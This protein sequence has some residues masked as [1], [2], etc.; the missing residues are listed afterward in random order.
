MNENGFDL[1]VGGH[2]VILIL[3]DDARHMART[4][5]ARYH[6][7][8]IASD[9]VFIYILAACLRDYLMVYAF[10]TTSIAKMFTNTTR[11]GSRSLE[12]SKFSG[13][14]LEMDFRT[15]ALFAV[16]IYI[17]LVFKGDFPR[18]SRI[19][20]PASG[21]TKKFLKMIFHQGRQTLGTQRSD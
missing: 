7:P 14:N 21:Y 10:F 4:W 8:I 6:S 3:A 17:A 19:F 15:I 1:G 12:T 11:T 18:V 16:S 5:A 13:F 20:F 9:V 2:G